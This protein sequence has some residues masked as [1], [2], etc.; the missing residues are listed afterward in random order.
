MSS[1]R[2]RDGTRP[3]EL[4]C[5]ACGR[6]VETVVTRHKTFGINVPQWRAGPCHNPDCPDYVPELVPADALRHRAGEEQ[7]ERRQEERE[8]EAGPPA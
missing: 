4:Q 6:P 8:K 3:T 5:A 1:D 2:E 7:A